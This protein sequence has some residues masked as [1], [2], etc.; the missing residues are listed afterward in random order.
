M[1]SLSQ[2]LLVFVISSLTVVLLIIGIQVIR[3]LSE[4]KVSL[5][6]TNQILD[7]VTVVSHAVAKPV[8]SVSE[9]VSGLKKGAKVVDMAEELL[10][11]RL[12]P[13]NKSKK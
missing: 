7:D 10:T 1:F 11:K 8:E 3:I 4:L 2:Y 9:F 12:E 5:K 13:K 6:K